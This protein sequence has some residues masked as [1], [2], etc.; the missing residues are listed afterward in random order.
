MQGSRSR[1]HD[2]LPFDP[3]IER[4]LRNI[5][6]EIRTIESSPPPEIA[7]E[8]PKLLRKYFTPTIYTSPSCIRL[9][10][11]EQLYNMK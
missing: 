8:Q 4:T 3:E 10:E 11:V 2:L 9:P 6:V 1:V 5:R 7:E